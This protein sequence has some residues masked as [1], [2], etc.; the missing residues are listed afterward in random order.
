MFPAGDAGTCAVSADCDPP[1]AAAA[2]AAATSSTATA[3]CPP[4]KILPGHLMHA[5]CIMDFLSPFS[6]Y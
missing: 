3:T 1:G 4:S 2:A 6:S 5:W